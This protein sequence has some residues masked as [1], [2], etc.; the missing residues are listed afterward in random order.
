M[1]NT[2]YRRIIIYLG[3]PAQFHFFKNII[4]NLRKDG[5][6]VKILLKTKD[7]LEQLVQ[8]TGYDYINIQKQVRKNNYFS[9]AKASLARTF[10]MLKIAH[11]YRPNMI[12]GTDASVAQVSKLLRIPGITVLEDDIE[13][14]TKM[15]KLA[16]PF[17]DSIVVPSV[18]RVGKWEAKKIPYYGY[19]KLAYLHPN[20]FTPDEA[21]VKKY[22]SEE[23]YCI[24]RLA[25]L[26]AFHDVGING[27][28]VDL[29]SNIISQAKEHGYRIYISSESE[30]DESLKE[31]QLTIQPTD[32]HHIMSFASLIISDS[33]SMSVEAAMLG[34]P[35]LRFS[36]F[37]GRIRVLEELEHKYGLTYGIKTNNPQE[38]CKKTAEFF[39]MPSLRE[40][41][42]KRRQKM[43]DEKIDVT[44]F[45][46]WFIENYPES[47]ETMKR[48]PD[49]QYNFK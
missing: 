28:N 12:I 47:K 3:H 23:K 27:L 33:Q 32:M 17:S 34:I 9:I 30:L 41:F 14:I 39:T 16:F 49:Y 19:M 45:F 37:S 20:R 2:K 4:E 15:A 26:T 1:K 42:Q 36:D 35:S 22:I 43:L 38:L 11:N 5:H 10:A 6:E 8:E 29:V 31:Y 13:I 18:C 24:V 48:N 21:I 40:T 44:A 25:Q 46:V 7:I